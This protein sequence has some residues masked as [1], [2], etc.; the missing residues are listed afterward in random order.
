VA[1]SKTLKKLHS[2]EMIKA[3]VNVV[4][5]LWSKMEAKV[6]EMAQGDGL[7]VNT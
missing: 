7:V 4:G 6:T 3:V 5:D 2:P 1:C